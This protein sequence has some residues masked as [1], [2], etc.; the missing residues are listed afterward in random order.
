MYPFKK[1]DIPSIIREN[2][3]IHG[4]KRRLSLQYKEDI[5][6]GNAGWMNSVKRRVRS[7]DI[8]EVV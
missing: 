7:T 4:R 1:P 2:F 5:Q 3:S 6:I 8:D